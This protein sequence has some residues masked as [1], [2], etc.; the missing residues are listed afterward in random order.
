M[1]GK[2]KDY[3]DLRALEIG[4]GSDKSSDALDEDD[5]DME[6][7]DPVGAQSIYGEQYDVMRRR[8]ALRA[9]GH[10]ETRGQLDIAMLQGM[11]Q[12]VAMG[13]CEAHCS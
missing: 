6:D 10:C 8:C 13:I 2:L 12:N 7:S 4:A 5:L 9:G 11:S 1:V 3:C